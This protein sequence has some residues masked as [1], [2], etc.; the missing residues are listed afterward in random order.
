MSFLTDVVS[1]TA[2]LIQGV[3]KYQAK[4]ILLKIDEQ[5]MALEN[6][7]KRMCFWC[8][9]LA[10]VIFVLMAGIGL[11]IAGF[12]MLLAPATGP[13]TAAL[14]VGVVISSL[15]AVLMVTLKSSKG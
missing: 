2:E 14:I 8:G 9:I 3:V 7:F 15:A 5:V 12:Y 13:G 11:I 1:T 4:S 10:I 6:R